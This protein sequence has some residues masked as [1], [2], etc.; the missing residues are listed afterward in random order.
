[1]PRQFCLLRE[2]ESDVTRGMYY[3]NI[4]FD[5]IPRDHSF[6]EWFTQL[7]QRLDE[8]YQTTR[9]SIN[10]GEKIEFHEL[11]FQCQVLRLNRPSPCCPQPTKEM[12]KKALQ[13][14]IAV[15]KE[16]G[17][18]ERMGKL[19]NIWHAGYY[20]IEAVICLLG[21]VLTEMGSQR[22]AHITLDGED[23]PILCRYV[24][25][26]PALLKKISRRWPNIA[27]HASAIEALSRAVIDALHLWSKSDSVEHVEI[28]ALKLQ[29]NQFS[30]FSPLPKETESS[31]QTYIPS[32]TPELYEAPSGNPVSGSVNPPFDHLDL[33]VPEVIAAPNNDCA[34]S[35][36]VQDQASSMIPG[37]YD[38]DMGS[39]L[40]WDFDGI[41]TEEILAAFLEVET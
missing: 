7:Q 31:A 27:V 9:Q 18:I 11:L 4:H 30:L 41:D 6:I 13:A 12:R 21:T 25:T 14:S 5:D 20:L 16:L 15:L 36:L 2:L 37:P 39:D 22:D 8:W 23:I 29:L 10:L 3:P 40:L 19:F 33:Q 34:L 17:I 26:A 38:F 28:T 24:Q 1:M 35:N 32:G